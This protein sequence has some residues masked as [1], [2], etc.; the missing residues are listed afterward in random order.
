MSKQRN[1]TFAQFFRYLGKRLW[2]TFLGILVFVILDLIVLAWL[3]LSPDSVPMPLLIIAGGT[4][5]GWPVLIAGLFGNMLFVREAERG[6]DS[7]PDS[8]ESRA[9]ETALTERLREELE[10]R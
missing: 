2:W 9:A 6:E 7:G 8:P 5:L 1:V 4:L 10:Q 3:R